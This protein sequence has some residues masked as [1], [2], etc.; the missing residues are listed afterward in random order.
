MRLKSF[1]LSL[2]LLPSL[3]MADDIQPF[4]PCWAGSS[5]SDGKG[6]V[7]IVNS[8]KDGKFLLRP[9]PCKVKD[10]GSLTGTVFDSDNTGKCLSFEFTYITTDKDK[11]RGKRWA[12]GG[13]AF[14]NSWASMDISTAKYLVFF[15]RSNAPGIDFALSL[16]G[17]AEGSETGELMVSDF[18]EGKKIGTEWAKVAIPLVSFPSLSKLNLAQVKTVHLVHL[19]DETYPENKPVFIHMDKMYFTDAKLVTPVENLGWIRAGDGINLIW[20]K[21]NDEGIEKYNLLV[22]EKIV[23]VVKNPKGRRAKIPASALPGKGSHVVGVASVAGKMISAAQSVTVTLMPAQETTASVSVS[24]KDGRAISPYIYGVNGWS[25]DSLGLKKLGV[26]VNRWGGN[27]TT[28]YNWKDD[29]MNR[30]LDWFFLNSADSPIGAKENEKSYYKFCQGSLAAGT[31][32]MTTI[33]LIGWVAKHPPAD[34]SRLSSFP[35]SLFP[36]Q[37]EQDNG[38]GKGF[39][40]TKLETKFAVW[41]NDPTA[42]YVAS[43]PEFQ[44]GW[45]QALVQAF[46]PAS[47][48]GVKF[49]SMDNEPGLWK[50]NHRDVRPQG[51]GME[52]L[53]NLNATYSAMVKSV[54]PQAQVVGMVSWGVMELEGSDWDYMQGGKAGYKLGDSGLNETNKWTDRKA[55]GDLPQAI[56]FLQEMKKRSAKAGVRLLDYFDNHGF[57]EVWGTTAKG[58]KV[59]VMG[60]FA[61]DPVMTPKQFDALRIL[62]DD[63]FVSEDSWCYAY[64]N[65]PHLWTPWVGL[66]PKLKKYIAENY[67]GT[68]LAMTEYYPASKSYFHGGLLEALNLGI[69]MREGMDLACDWGGVDRENYVFYGHMLFSNY[70][71]LGSKVGGNYLDATSSSPDLYSFGARDGKKTFVVLINKN[72][73]SAMKT[74]VALPAAATTYSTFTLSE[75]LGR[76]LFNSGPQKAA[77]ASLN[78]DVPAFSALLVVAQ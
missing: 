41:G 25:L 62:W 12:G 14:N 13:I 59:N 55:H 70:D 74:A 60:D 7:S 58:D 71:K 3:V 34:G 30:G 49:Y 11:F 18:V 57:P 33:P 73:D 40:S 48:K 21:A 29:A 47:G 67:P 42:N 1:L 64:G 37:A 17:A 76:R 39:T 23:G 75:T 24:D 72:H 15:V 51:V 38:A 44:K 4:G 35:L 46:G 26:T 69:F 52:E 36:G 65:A 16:T 20:D 66:I 8:G 19:Q 6:G 22:D 9:D 77:G 50:W 28:S 68:K 61:Y 53:V 5:G 10:S 31:Q 43:T 56:Y 78:I 54:D 2:I 27:A 63:T 32:V 45:V